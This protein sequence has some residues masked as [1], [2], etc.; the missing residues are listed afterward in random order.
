MSTP[1]F[2][3]SEL[4]YAIELVRQNYAGMKIKLDY[5]I[6]SVRHLDQLFDDAFKDG[7]IRNPESSFAKQ[8][9]LIMTGVAGY[10][11]EV[12]R[13]NVEGSTLVI[14][15]ADP[16]W[17]MH[18]KVMAPNGWQFQPG[19]RVLRRV[20]EGRESDLY[21]YTIAAIDY[22]KRADSEPLQIETMVLRGKKPW[23]KVW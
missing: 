14:D 7:E 6:T 11:A 16:Q 18:F 9:G 8:Q 4:L 10:I 17:Y 20:K 1:T 13:R 12:I 3:H 5:S 15:P 21:H 19:I 23:W 2:Q 22:A